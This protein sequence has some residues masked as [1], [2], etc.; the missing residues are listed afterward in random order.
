MENVLELI[1]E[2][3]TNLT[4]HSS[5]FNEVLERTLCLSDGDDNLRRIEIDTTWLWWL[6]RLEVDDQ[7]LCW[8]VSQFEVHFK[9]LS[10]SGGSWDRITCF[11][12]T[13]LELWLALDFKVGIWDLGEDV[14]WTW[15]LAVKLFFRPRDTVSTR[16]DWQERL[17]SEVN[18]CADWC[19]EE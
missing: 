1:I 9:R 15:V 13:L 14:I 2:V 16:F 8:W 6:I 18:N 3:V 11:Q 7:I 19:W 10:I 4:R 5:V 17:D 12:L